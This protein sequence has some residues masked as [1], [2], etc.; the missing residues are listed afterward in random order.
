M[1]TI[2]LDADIIA[3]QTAS[4]CEVEIR[5]PITGIHTL[6]SDPGVAIPEFDS[7]VDKIVKLLGARRV[8]CAITD[9]ENLNFRKKVLPTYKGNRTKRKPLCLTALE[10]HIKEKYQT[11]IFPGLEADDVLGIIATIPS[12]EKK[13]IVSVDKD[14]ESIPCNLFNINKDIVN[15]QPKIRRITKKVAD[16]NFLKQALMGDAVDGYKGCPGY[17]VKTA[18][19]MLDSK[20]ATWKTVLDC[21]IKAGFTEE[22]A[23]A[24]ARCA[25]ILRNEDFDNQKKEVILWKPK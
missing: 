23:L 13:V 25:R 3:Y 9:R 18:E 7:S 17:G 20:G 6:H 21:Y 1:T 12:K 8:I 4:N 11:Y 5:W 10:D 2:L 15:G 24:Q 22:D 16:Y 19:K 14:F